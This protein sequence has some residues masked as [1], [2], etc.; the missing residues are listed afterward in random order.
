MKE[1]EIRQHLKMVI[2]DELFANSPRYSDLLTYLVEKS[3][4]GENLKEV[5]IGSEFFSK[6][7]DDSE[8][9]SGGVRVYMFNL[10]KKLAEYY[11]SRGANDKIQFELNKGS[12][13]ISFVQTPM[14]NKWGKLT[15]ITAAI[16][17]I[18]ALAI[19]LYN[20]TQR[21]DLYC[22]SEFINNNTPITVV[23]ADHI[24]VRS[25]MDDQ[26]V[27]ILHPEIWSNKSYL[28]Y[29]EENHCDTLRLASFPFYT[30][31]IPYAVCELTRWFD[32]YEK[33]FEIISESEF[34]IKDTNS[35]NIVYI[36]QSK[37][38]ALSNEIFLK[39]SKVFS[40][41]GDIVYVTKDGTTKEY[42]PQFSGESSL[43]EYAIIS[44]LPLHNG[45]VALYFVS[46]ND[47]GTM[48]T[49]KRFTNR[50]LLKEIY[51]ELPSENQYFNALFRVNGVQRSEI[52]CELIELEIIDE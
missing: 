2:E 13:N 18:L 12:Y 29:I 1:S 6:S 9:S 47:V 41:D 39:N 27:L 32:R 23:L 52:K 36:G 48:A 20:N 24:S 3:I 35:S 26:P 37:I 10:R 45:N 51:K 50:E 15:L 38:M 14:V 22:W 46:N 40:V 28:D 7:Y 31:A 49:V 25:K 21:K 5:T 42:R 43:E 8:K 11:Q 16:I 34:K 44:Y 33:E 17:A 4:Q 30:K 19:T